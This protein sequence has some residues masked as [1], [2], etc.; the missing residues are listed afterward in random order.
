MNNYYGAYCDNLLDWQMML[1]VIRLIPELK[2]IARNRKVQR[3]LAA[4]GIK[5]RVLPAYPQG[6]LMCRLSAHKFTAAG[7]KKIGMRHG[8]FHFKELPGKGAFLLFSRFI[9]TSENEA[10]IALKKGITNGI[11]LGYPRLDAFFKGEISLEE[12]KFL[13]R[14]L[15]FDNNKK[16]LLFTATWPASGMSALEIWKKRIRELILEFNVLVTLHPW[17]DPAISEYFEQMPGVHLIKDYEN[18]PYIMLADIC[19]GDTSSILAE[20]CALDKPIITFTVPPAPRFVPYV[21]DMI[22]DFSLQINGFDELLPAINRYIKEPDL[23]K[24]ARE[25]ARKLMFSNTDGSAGIKIA[26]LIRSEF[27]LAQPPVL[28]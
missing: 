2:I 6:V 17:T 21:L 24:T 13:K 14:K 10:D 22:K 23:K 4:K 25:R 11:G 27:N 26:E 16:N 20:C 7:I 19:I 12:I 9:F 15:K 18:I 1:P 5:S 28:R 8:P 3:G